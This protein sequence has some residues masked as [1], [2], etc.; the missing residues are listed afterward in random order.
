[1]FKI[2]LTKDKCIGCGA[3]SAV[4]PAN[5]EMGEDGK[6]IVLKSSVEI[7]GCNK[8]A[9]ESCPNQ[10]IIVEPLISLGK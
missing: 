4:C 9:E 3:C 2:L 5:Y 10:A 7:L 1:M 8:L 6:A